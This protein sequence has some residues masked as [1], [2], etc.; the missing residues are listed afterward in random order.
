MKKVALDTNAVIE[1][2]KDEELF[3]N[4]FSGFKLILPLTVWAELFFGALNA[5]NPQKHLNI[6]TRF[7]FYVDIL[8]PDEDTAKIYA[9]LRLTLKKKGRPIP[10]ND[11]WIAALCVQH[12]LPLFTKDVHFQNIEELDLLS[13]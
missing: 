12:R 13:W 2:F 1:I 3:K 8:L 11:I 9:E 10:E 4:T 6:L 5:G 7:R